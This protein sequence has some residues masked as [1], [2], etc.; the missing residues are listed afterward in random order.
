MAES[1]YATPR[2]LA[3]P[4]HQMLQMLPATVVDITLPAVM[5]TRPG[6]RMVFAV[7][8]FSIPVGGMDIA[9]GGIQGFMTQK[10]LKSCRISTFFSQISSETMPQG[11]C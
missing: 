9:G 7:S 5:S 3:F 6:Q 1:R 2:N 4:L 11:M 10:N 8:L